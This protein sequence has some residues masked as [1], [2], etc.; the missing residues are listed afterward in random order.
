VLPF[1]SKEFSAPVRFYGQLKHGIAVTKGKR[2]K[3]RMHQRAPTK[4]ASSLSLSLY[5]SSLSLSLSLLLLS[6]AEDGSS[7][8]LSLSLSL[9]VERRRSEVC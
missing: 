1:D 5:L 2:I 4:N 6:T 7:L 9:S 3:T 8:S